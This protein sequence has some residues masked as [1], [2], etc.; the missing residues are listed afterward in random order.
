MYAALARAVLDEAD[1]DRAASEVKRLRRRHPR[2][3]KDELAARLI[4]RAAAQC[5]S[6]GALLTAP[7]A[8]FGSMP[9]GAGLA[10]QVVALKR[11]VLALAAV[12]A[13]APSARERAS[14]VAVAAGA[15]IGSEVLRQG[16]VRLLK[17][18]APR[19][20]AARTALGALVGGTLGYG[21]AVAI[22]GFA[23]NAFRRGRVLAPVRRVLR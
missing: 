18:V 5:A 20:S 10:W 15:G 9:F 16:L 13:R 21:A 2:A 1:A 23:R 12:Y 8:F 14:G 17:R 7:A 4:R 6:A 3:S 19:R 22:G 11:L